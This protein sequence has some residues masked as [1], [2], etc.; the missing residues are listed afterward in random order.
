M[1]ILP[2]DTRHVGHEPSYYPGGWDRPERYR[3]M[4]LL[5]A[6]VPQA[7]QAVANALSV[8][9][10]IEKMKLRRSAKRAVGA[11]TSATGDWIC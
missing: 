10:G 11:D 9:A 4:T 5:V 6:L 3:R 7:L 2:S 8:H 1:I